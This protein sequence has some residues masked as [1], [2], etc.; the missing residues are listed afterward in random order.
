MD[1]LKDEHPILQALAKALPYMPGFFD[2]EVSVALFNTEM[3]L[4]NQPPP[5]L[6][7]SGKYGD[8]IRPDSGAAIVIASDAPIVK[9]I[10]A[11]IYGVPFR[12]CSVPV[13][14][15]DGK[16]IGV[17]AV[18]RSLKRS[19]QMK[20]LSQE[21]SDFMSKAAGAIRELADDVQMLA[22][23]NVDIAEKSKKAKK[24]TEGSAQIVKMIQDISLQTNLL[25]INAA[26]EAAN[27]GQ[28]GRGFRVVAEEIQRL[29]K[30]TTQSVEKI[31]ASLK[32]MTSSVD[33]IAT[34][35]VSSNDTFQNQ[36]VVLQDIS[37]SLDKLNDIAE[38]VK[39]LADTL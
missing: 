25:G 11:H 5:S 12:S 32:E 6:P 13:H 10:P 22:V 31:E 34:K 4:I 17:F 23:A 21:L 2:D 36:A 38:Q 15:D 30:S 37:K 8:R 18:G 39:A 9:E 26:I 19:R 20:E 29:S 28:A 24:D 7:I 16:V 35:I 14:D 33:Y 1:F 3:L 27:S